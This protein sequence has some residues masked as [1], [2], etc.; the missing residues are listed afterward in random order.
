MKAGLCSPR[1]D[2]G[3]SQWKP[4]ELRAQ[5]ERTQVRVGQGPVGRSPTA[6]QHPWR[7][8]VEEWTEQVVHS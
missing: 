4:N 6:P 8:K 3:G 1:F 7:P 2:V 5:A